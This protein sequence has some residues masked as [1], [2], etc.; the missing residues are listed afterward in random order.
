MKH[1]LLTAAISAVLL[2]FFA[3][4]LAFTLYGAGSAIFGFLMIG[5]LIVLQTPIFC[6]CRRWGW[7]PIVDRKLYQP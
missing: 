3:V 5:G 6:I 4:P 2:L 7:I 1:R